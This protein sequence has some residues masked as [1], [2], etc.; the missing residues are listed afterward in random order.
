MT[1]MITMSDDRSEAAPGWWQPTRLPDSPPQIRAIFMIKTL[2]DPDLRTPLP[3]LMNYSINL[4]SKIYWTLPLP[5]SNLISVWG[6]FSFY[7][8]YVPWRCLECYWWWWLSRFNVVRESSNSDCTSGSGND[9][10]LQVSTCT[11]I[12]ELMGHTF[13]H[14]FYAVTLLPRQDVDNRY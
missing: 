13:I 14:I 6:L 7:L 1:M 8:I 3:P 4:Q 9:W 11:D 10:G 5:T 12:T 2:M